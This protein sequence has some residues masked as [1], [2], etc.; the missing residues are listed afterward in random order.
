MAEEYFLASKPLMAAACHLAI[1]DTSQAL[2]RLVQG[3]EVEVATAILLALKLDSEEV[4]QAMAQ[5]CEHL[6]QFH[7]AFTC[8]SNLSDPAVPVCALTCPRQ[9][10]SLGHFLFV[11]FFRSNFLP[12]DVPV[13]IKK[14]LT[15]I[16]N[17]VCHPKKN[18]NPKRRKHW[19][20]DTC[21]RQLDA[22]PQPVKILPLLGL[23]SNK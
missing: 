9:F 13:P 14:D 3:N 6:G 12:Q 4:W 15:F 2:R 16:R 5:R 7:E 18:L 1:G 20:P 19:K 10:Q 11:C 23:V 17:A 8:L 21:S 22:L